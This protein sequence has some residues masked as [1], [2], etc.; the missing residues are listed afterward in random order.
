MMILRTFFIAFRYLI[1]L[2]KART[3]HGIHS[4]FVF[5]FINLVLRDSREYPGYQLVEKQRS[6]LFRNPNLVE[7]IDFG[8]GKGRIGYS[9]HLRRVKDIAARSGI[10]VKY[11]RLLHRI[12]LYYKPKVMIE[13]GTS[14]GISTMYQSAAAPD[15]RF[16]ALE[17][18]AST[19]E[20]AITNLNSIGATN[21]H[22][23]V[24]NF[25]IVMPGLLSQIATIDHAFIDGNHT[26]EATLRY[27]GQLVKHA[28]NNSV[29]IFH[30]IHWSAEMEQA[31]EEIKNHEKVVITIDLFHMGLVFFRKELSRQH[32]I[33][34]F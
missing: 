2:V 20:F 32:F 15:I 25:D 13:L 30:D 26:R 29:Y 12:V 10:S 21:A 11:G 6:L 5:D 22:F 24:G 3:R 14:L 23:T 1:Y 9:T 4:P 18:C 8:A 31:W 27:F 34:R 16:L 17:G 7:V 33:I 19:A 28:G